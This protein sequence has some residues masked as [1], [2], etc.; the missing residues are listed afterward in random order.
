MIYADHYVLILFSIVYHWNDV[1][2]IMYLYV[3][4]L[5]TWWACL[6]NSSDAFLF[7]FLQIDSD[8]VIT[9]DEQI[10]L[11]IGAHARC[12]RSIKAQMPLIKGL[13]T[14]F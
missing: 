10:Y 4:L 8:D 14:S 5:T 13:G 12:E 2:A 6:H 7:L 3:V 11:L 1:Y 9:R